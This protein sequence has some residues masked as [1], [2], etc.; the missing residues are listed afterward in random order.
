MVSHSDRQV[1]SACPFAH[2]AVA[3]VQMNSRNALMQVLPSI[4][5]M[6]LISVAMLLLIT[7]RVS[8]LVTTLPPRPGQDESCPVV[9]QPQQQ[10]AQH[11]HGSEPHSQR[12]EEKWPDSTSCAVA[13]SALTAATGVATGLDMCG[14]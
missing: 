2:V 12:P 10:T 13:T 6:A 8:P 4:F 3:P 5:G 1:C 7:G 11:V 9:M 14:T